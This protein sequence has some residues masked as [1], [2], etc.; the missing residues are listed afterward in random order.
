MA[1][2]DVLG[3]NLKAWFYDG[4]NAST[5]T[6]TKDSAS[7]AS[8]VNFTQSS[9]GL[10]PTEVTTPGGE[11]AV[12]FAFNGT[13]PDTSADQL[14]GGGVG[15]LSSDR[16]LLMAFCINATD[17]GTTQQIFRDDSDG[18]VQ[19]NSSGI[20]STTEG[21]D[22]D[23]SIYGDWHTIILVWDMDGGEN[24]LYVDG[25]EQATV[26]TGTFPDGWPP[27]GYYNSFEFGPHNPGGIYVSGELDADIASVV[28]AS[29]STAFTGTE[30][31]DLHD[32]LQLI[33]DGTATVKDGAATIS[34]TSSITATGT[35][36][37]FRS[38]S[39]TGDS[40]LTAVA[41][42]AK[43][44]AM[45]TAG[46]G[47]LVAVG[48]GAKLSSVAI[49]NTSSITA[50]G[51]KAEPRAFATTG[52]GTLAAVGTRAKFGSAA[53]DGQGSISR[54]IIKTAAVAIAAAAESTFIARVLKYVA[55]VIA[56]AAITSY[57]F[58][59][60]LFRS[61][62][63]GATSEI[64]AVAE[65]GYKDAACTITGDSTLV[66]VAT[67]AKFGA[68]EIEGAGSLRVTTGSSPIYFL[69]VRFR[70]RANFMR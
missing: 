18:G 16:F 43:F 10:R 40:T 53:I 24:T 32:E 3:S 57:G 7:H 55:A 9:S 11:P 38:L 21:A 23:S 12:R 33:I 63:I 59:K 44:G 47:T 61:V 70:G 67:V 42:K 26:G 58:L 4:Y 15:G 39:V 62:A 30:I 2:T 1:V 28:F 27:G 37:E 48:T 56:A 22:S 20:L 31:S 65:E 41:T 45:A 36:A 29:K 52:D 54:S 49:S 14:Q 8:T 64:T 35:H 19:I 6:W 60:N 46:D 5:G 34:N 69:T 50:T 25:V 51:Q 66:A 68:V 13:N 17:N